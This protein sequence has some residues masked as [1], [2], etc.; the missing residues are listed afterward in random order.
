[1]RGWG[2]DGGDVG[3]QKQC[4]VERK[5]SLAN[6]MALL[7]PIFRTDKRGLL[8]A[9]RK[10]ERCKV[11]KKKRLSRE[12]NDSRRSKRVERTSYN[13]AGRERVGP[14]GELGVTARGGK[15]TPREVHSLEGRKQV[16]IT[17]S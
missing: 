16:N 17:N 4:G 9:G 10:Q 5:P 12:R 2:D 15:G 8:G 14:G 13:M 1:M 3:K 6:G 7:L 11:K